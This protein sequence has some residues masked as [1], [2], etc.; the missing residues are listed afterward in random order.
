[1]H[2]KI[3]RCVM[4]FAVATLV[5]CVPIVALTSDYAYAGGG[6]NC[7]SEPTSTSHCCSCDDPPGPTDCDSAQSSARVGCGDDWC[8]P[9]G[10]IYVS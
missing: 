7:G 6:D 4:L 1:M 9:Q 3:R 5:F 2:L 10:C 8:E